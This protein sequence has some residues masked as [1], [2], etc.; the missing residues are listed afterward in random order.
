MV[1]V[2]TGGIPFIVFVPILPVPLAFV[3]FLTQALPICSVADTAQN[4]VDR[5]AQ[6]PSGPV[7]EL[8][9]SGQAHRCIRKIVG[10]KETQRA[11]ISTMLIRTCETPFISDPGPDRG[12]PVPNRRM[13]AVVRSGFRM[14]RRRCGPAWRRRRRDRR[15]VTRQPIVAVFQRRV[16]VS[17]VIPVVTVP[18]AVTVIVS[19]PL[20]L[21]GVSD[22]DQDIGKQLIGMRVGKCKT[23]HTRKRQSGNGC[24]QY[25]ASSQ[26]GHFFG[27]LKRF[28][29]IGGLTR[30]EA[31]GAAIITRAS[32]GTVTAGSGAATLVAGASSAVARTTGTPRPGGLP[33][34]Q[35]PRC[36]R[37]GDYGL[38]PV[39]DEVAGAER[40]AHSETARNLDIG[41]ACNGGLHS[42]SNGRPNDLDRSGSRM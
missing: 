32:A 12:L 33:G 42:A 23:R 18:V 14:V 34:P 2:L 20:S 19:N 13:S 16:P 26:C 25:V 30:S 39:P 38:G 24:L 5:A 28:N 9:R 37:A 21:Q 17:S 6:R 41:S 15:W 7:P 3:S 11:S 10:V 31:T 27:S 8:W 22:A 4:I 35:G 40:A 36:R 29:Q 1:A